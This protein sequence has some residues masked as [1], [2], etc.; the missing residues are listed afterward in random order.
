[1]VDEQNQHFSNLI[2]P[3]SRPPGAAAL[4][5]GGGERRDWRW[6]GEEEAT[7][8]RLGFLFKILRAP[9]HGGVELRGWAVNGGLLA[10]TEWAGNGI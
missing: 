7:W 2:A 10:A 9:P 3:P 6:K 4:V 1:M 8:G 5:S